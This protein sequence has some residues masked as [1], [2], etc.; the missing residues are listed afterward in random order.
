MFICIFTLSLRLLPGGIYTPQCLS[1]TVTLLLQDLL[2][3]ERGFSSFKLP[4]IGIP[5]TSFIYPAVLERGGK[6][7][8]VIC[9]NASSLVHFHHFKT[10][11]YLKHETKSGEGE[12]RVRAFNSEWRIRYV[13]VLRELKTTHWRRL[14]ISGQ[15]TY[16]DKSKNLFISK[17]RIISE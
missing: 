17:E 9:H 3:K 8:L 6:T 7:Y 14:R 2:E 4:V 12:S 15:Y 16:V 13:F 11:F 10:V 1:E 5:E